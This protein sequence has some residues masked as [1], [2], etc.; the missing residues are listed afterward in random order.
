MNWIPFYFDEIS[1]RLIKGIPPAAKIKS[2]RIKSNNISRNAHVK[3]HNFKA[4]LYMVAVGEWFG[5]IALLPE[6]LVIRFETKADV[7]VWAK[8]RSLNTSAFITIQ[9]TLI[10]N[11]F[12]IFIGDL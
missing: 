2:M 10:A 1:E 8:F 9:V 5:K 4:T 7:V 11:K 3:R 6:V 12:K